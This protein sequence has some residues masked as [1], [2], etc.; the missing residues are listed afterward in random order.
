MKEILWAR[1]RLHINGT[2]YGH[3]YAIGLNIFKVG[4]VLSLLN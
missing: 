1:E 3:I 2:P 4:Y